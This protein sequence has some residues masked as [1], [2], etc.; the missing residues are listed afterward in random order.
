[1]KANR[2]ASEKVAISDQSGLTNGIVID[3]AVNPSPI[4]RNKI[5]N[6]PKKAM[7]ETA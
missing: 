4:S 3:V 5:N 7:I 2:L 6:A 1:M